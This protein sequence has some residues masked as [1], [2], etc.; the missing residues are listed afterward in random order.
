MSCTIADYTSPKMSF[1]MSNHF[2]ILSYFLGLVMSLINIT[3]ICHTIYIFCLT[4]IPL[5]FILLH[6]SPLPLTP[7]VIVPQPIAHIVPLPLTITPSH[8]KLS[9]TTTTLVTSP[10]TI[11]SIFPLKSHPFILL[12][13]HHQSILIQ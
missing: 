5:A 13:S 3:L 4:L 1:S 6:L 9:H 2:L 11:T 7:I 10:S 8:T 12:L